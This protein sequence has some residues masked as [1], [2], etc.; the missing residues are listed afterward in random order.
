[1]ASYILRRLL[2]AI[3]TL[4]GITLITFFLML[5][6]PGD[7]VDQITFRNQQTTPEQEERL[8]R[9]LG[10]DQPALM[11][12]VFW[13]V[14]NDWTMIDVDGD[15]VGE[16]QGVRRGFLRG[17][18]GNSLTQRRPVTELILERVPATLQLTL[19]ALVIGYLIGIPLGVLA[20]VYHRSW[21]D[22]F[23]R[24]V[25]VL[26]TALPSFWMA[27]ILI[28]IFAVTLDVLP[29]SGMRD[30]NNPNST[31]LD[32]AK[33]MVLPVSV[34]ALGTIASVSR[35][36]RTKMMEV[37]NQDYIRTAHAKGLSG[38]VVWWRH[39]LKN[40]LL[41]I[42]TMLGP[43]IGLMLGGAVI[44]EQIFSWP[45]MGRLVVNAVQE[46]D[47]PL[48]M[49]SVVMSAT[50]YVVGLLISDLLYSVVDPRIR[51]N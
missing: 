41:P 33:Y 24:I 13:L 31:F 26:G 35:F 27:L 51:L 15:G 8:R 16:L 2:Q 48:V 45:G 50:L 42:V 11:Q 25:S 44:V 3:P 38:R 40:A 6:T 17:D 29:I 18:L 20:A 10:L 21:V 39:A 23:A 19:T 46:R 14:G 7:P 1:M 37:L 5:A 32:N 12:Y 30:V 9:Q 4:M 34:L 49:G 22:Q 43:A 47:H 28:L 36:L